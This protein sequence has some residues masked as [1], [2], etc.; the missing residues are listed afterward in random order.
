M[1]T[2]AIDFAHAQHADILSSQGQTD[3]QKLRHYMAAAL[4]IQAVFTVLDKLLPAEAQTVEKV[5][6]DL[7]AK[8]RVLAS[9][10]TKQSDI[11][12]LLVNNYGQIDV[13]DKK[14]TLDQ[15]VEFFTSTLN[16]TTSQLLTIA[17]K[18][19]AM[20]YGLEDAIKHLHEIEI[21]SKN[22]QSITK[23]THLLALNASI[24]AASAGAAG[25]GFSVVANEVKDVSRQ[26]TEISMLMNERTRSISK[27][28]MDGYEML[29][30]VATADM[31]GS[32]A[33]KETLEQMLRGLKDQIL[34]AKKTMGESMGTSKNIANAIGSMIV[35]LQFQDRNSQ[36]AGNAT[37]MLR[38]CGELITHQRQQMPKIPGMDDADDD[39]DQKTKEAFEH[40]F[41]TI[42][43]GD[44]RYQY[45]EAL[46]M[47]GGSFGGMALV[48]EKPKTD[49]VDLF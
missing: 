32:M 15:F 13:G 21:F 10:A 44:I 36:I 47:M 46:R 16:N 14:V 17:K 7:T 5:T 11:I 19:I 34:I 12:E 18:S 39:A 4:A 24:E 41:A 9:E 22:I 38:A 28:V 27:C 8:F 30:D 42:K 43:L 1:T 20:V 40:I 37:D 48:Q 45:L 25:K 29:K 23:K 2:L 31:E 26:I 3:S 6:C 49:D 33:A 35:D